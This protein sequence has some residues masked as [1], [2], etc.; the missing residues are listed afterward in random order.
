MNSRKILVLGGGF[1]GLWSAVGA[2][3]TLDKL[4][5]GCEEVAITLVNADPYHCIRVRNYEADLSSARVPLDDVLGP[6]GVERVEGRVTGIHLSNQQVQVQM[7]GAGELTSLEYDRLVLALGSQLNWPKIPGLSEYGF[8]VDT[9]GGAVR[10]HAHLQSLATRGQSPGVYTVVIVAAG[11]TGIETATEMPGRLRAILAAAQLKCPFQVI[12]VDRNPWIG[13]DMGNSARPVIEQALRD[14]GIETRTGVSIASIDV[15]GVQLESGEVIPAA[16]VVWCGGMKANPL[17]RQFLID[18]DRFGRLPVDEFLKV[19]GVE[20]VFAAGDVA[21]AMMDDTHTSVMSCQHARPMGRFAGHNVVCDLLKQPM[22]P[23]HI[24]WYVTVLDLGPWGAV[25]TQGW[26]R[27]VASSGAAAKRTKQTINCHRIY[28]PLTRN[29]REILDA[30]EPAV[31]T[32][33]AFGH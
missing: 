15:S 18:R 17:T 11:L 13:S 2:A 8:D 10:L 20:N 16:T 28:P 21:S 19:K 24:E 5:L 9:Y 6:V 1:A 30:A 3:R 12:L 33:P 7:S 31:Q 23:L 22:L 4:G 25:Y 32:P 14:L 29:R 27:T 26:E